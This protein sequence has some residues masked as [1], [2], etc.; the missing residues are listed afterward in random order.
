MDA[1]ML[2]LDT[3]LGEANKELESLRLPGATTTTTGA[4]RTGAAG[5]AEAAEEEEIVI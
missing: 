1:A 4:E 5:A 3:V 2:E